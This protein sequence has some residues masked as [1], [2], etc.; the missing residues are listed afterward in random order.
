M[1]EKLFTSAKGRI[2]IDHLSKILRIEKKHIARIAFAISLA[3]EW[4][5]VP[6][7][8]D[9]RGTE[10][11]KYTLAWDDSLSLFYRKAIELTYQKKLTEDEF[12]WNESIFKNH[13]D[14]WLE[15]LSDLFESTKRDK[16]K[17][18]IELAKIVSPYSAVWQKSWIPQLNIDLWFDNAWKGVVIELNNMKKHGNSHLAIMGRP[19][20]WKTQSLLNI[21]AQIREKSNYA[22]NFIFFDYKWDVIMTKRS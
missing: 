20:Q 1:S 5:C 8:T 22:T 2:T 13:V 12:F 19:W 9:S 15:I 18:V 10:F 11:N 7:S 21:L 14:S 16:S 17:F 3:Q 6:M 4:S